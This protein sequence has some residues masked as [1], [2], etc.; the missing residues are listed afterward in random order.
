MVS[1][2]LSRIFD[3]HRDAVHSV[4]DVDAVGATAG[5][6]PP[7]FAEFACASIPAGG[8]RMPLK[9]DVRYVAAGDGVH[10][11][12]QVVGEGPIDLV[13]VPPSVSQVEASWEEPSLARF[14]S[15][16][17]G[18]GRL[19]VFDKRGTGMSDR[20][21]DDQMPGLDM[22]V[23]DMVAVLNDIGAERVVPIGY[24]D[25]GPGAMLF[26]T[27][28]ASRTA[29]LILI[30]TCARLIEGPG[31]PGV[32]LPFAKAFMDISVREWGSGVGLPMLA[33]TVA[34]DR[35]LQAWWAKYQ[36]VSASPGAVRQVFWM[37]I[38]R[39]VRDLLP[40]ISVPTL[41]IHHSL[42]ASIPMALGRYLAEHIPGARFVER[43]GND[44]MFWVSDQDGVLD[45]AADF[46]AEVLGE[47]S[48]LRA[49]SASARGASKRWGWESLTAAEID[50][51]RLVAEGLSNPD[52]ARKLF[53]SRYTVESHLKHI[54]TKLSLSS[55]A[56]L[57]AETTKRAS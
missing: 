44:H 48:I 22:R 38:E 28:Y 47:P 54:F 5:R 34:G 14:F 55:R 2:I 53:V 33:P 50:V 8:A 40:Q 13:L 3:P 46:L 16:L 4:E 20:V 52:I 32:P 6:K 49:R 27:R 12:Y 43:P 36:R 39:D 25:G 26:A 41:V 31:Y 17:A 18:L 7:G 11:A 1:Q 9:P 21:R 23:K 30:D 37:E 24:S 19:I 35:R 15:R 42:N 57:A 56:E 29:A 10:I 45:A 51:S